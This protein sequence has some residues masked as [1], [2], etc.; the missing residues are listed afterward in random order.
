MKSPATKE[1]IRITSYLINLFINSLIVKSLVVI[2]HAITPSISHSITENG[3][4]IKGLKIN[5]KFDFSFEL[6][7]FKL[8]PFEGK[9]Y[10]RNY[11][12]FV[13]LTWRNKEQKFFLTA[14]I[15]E[16]YFYEFGAN[17]DNLSIKF[18]KLLV[19]FGP[20]P[21]FHKSYGGLTGFD[22]KFLPVVWSELGIDVSY[23][24]FRTGRFIIANEVYV[25]NAPREDQTKVYLPNIGS[26][27]D[28]FAIGDRLTLGT[29]KFILYLSAYWN[30]Y[31]GKYN[32]VMGAFDV[33]FPYGFLGKEEIFRRLSLSAGILRSY[34]T[35]DR[36]TVGSYFHFANYARLNIM[37]PLNLELRLLT[38]VKTIQNYRGLFYDKSTADN[39]DTAS[40]NLALIYRIGLFSGQIQYIA[41]SEFA[42]EVEDNLF[43]VMFIFEF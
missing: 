2:A 35:G 14:E 11:H 40:Y 8:N 37:L 26:S 30:Q 23:T 41:N 34:A 12:H 25:V 19:P 4:E 33:A 22:Q 17:I 7:D 24:F 10:F 29:D 31:K 27:I 3:L 36:D 43:R 42:D 5:G 28:K 32:Y 39:S 1:K 18:G 15:I 16:R 21:L 13:F 20:D 38:G 6:R 9:A